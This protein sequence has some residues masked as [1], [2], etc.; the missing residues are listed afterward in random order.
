MQFRCPPPRYIVLGSLLLVTF[1]YLFS[2][3]SDSYA[4]RTSLANLKSMGR[5]GTSQDLVAEVEDWRYEEDV[6]NVTTTSVVVPRRANAAF[7]ILARNSDVW[8][9]V[10]SIRGMEDRFNARYNYPYVF[11]N[12]EVFSEEF[13]KHTSAIASGPCTYGKIDSSQWGDHPSWIDEDKAKAARQQ[14]EKDNVIYGGSVSYRHMC[15]YQS[16]FFWRHPLLDQYKYYWRIEPNVKYFCTIDYD[17]FLLMQDGDK[18][19]GFTVTIYEYASTIATLWD[20]TKDFIKANPEYLA[21]PNMMDWLSDDGGETYNR[22]HFWSN[23]EIASLDFWRGEAYQ[24]YFEHLDRAGGFFYERWG[25]APVHSIAASLFLKPEE[26]HFFQDIGYRHEPFQHCPKA[27]EDVCAC[28]PNSGDNFEVHGYS[29]TVK[30]KKVT[31]WE[32]KT[33]GVHYDTY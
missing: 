7:V 15:R 29:C 27:K 30:W 33:D 9:I 21:K 1:H 6:A 5:K 16:G 25:D 11:L 2:F 32:G 3:S 20:T 12:D 18:K 14:M 4:S 31:K 24:K 23:F 28:D 26:M 22:C 19:Y 17:P 10:A 13:K 8:E